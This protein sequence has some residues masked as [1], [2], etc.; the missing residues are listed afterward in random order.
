MRVSE[1]VKFVGER[2]KRECVWGRENQIK[3]LVVLV[4]L[5]KR[6]LTD[7]LCLMKIGVAQWKVR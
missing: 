6:K 1:R 7:S 5:L 4:F 2:E 3:L